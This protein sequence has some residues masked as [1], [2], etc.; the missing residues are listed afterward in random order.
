[1]DVGRT[2][3]PLS[4]SPGRSENTFERPTWPWQTR[5]ANSRRSS[6][7]SASSLQTPWEPQGTLSSPARPVSSSSSQSWTSSSGAMRQ[8]T[9]STVGYSASVEDSI[10]QWSF[11]G[12]EWT[13]RDVHKLRDFVEGIAEAEEGS[14]LEAE[15]FEI[16]KQAPLLG[17]EKFKLEIARADIGETS[18]VKPA[19][20]MLYITS[21][22][23]FTQNLNYE[24][25]AS[26]M[27][28]IKSQEDR[29][30]ARAE[31]VWEH[32]DAGW[33]F[34]HNSE[35]FDCSLPPISALLENPRIRE[36]DAFTICVQIHCPLG[37]FFPQ[38]PTAYYVPRDLLE[39]LEAS[40]DNPNTGDVRFICLERMTHDAE[41]PGTPLS[42]SAT[43]TRRPSSSASSLSPFSLQ[44]TARKR[45]IYAHSDILTRRS[46]YFATMLSSSFA[47]SKVT[48]GDRK[49]FTIVVEEAD[50]ETI[51]WLLKYCY[52]NWLQFKEND[53]PRL[54]V[55]G[56]GAGWSARW[57]SARGGEWDW[58]TFTKI[59]GDE[60]T[61]TDARSA[62]KRA[63]PNSL[64][65]FSTEL[66]A[67]PAQDVLQYNEH[68]SSIGNVVQLNS[69]AQPTYSHDG[70]AFFGWYFTLK[71]DPH[72]HPTPAP[73]PASALA[74][75][76][77]AH[78]YAMPAL[79]SLALDHMMS[80][81]TPSSAFGLLLATSVWDELHSLVMDYV[82]EK[83]ED[84]S[85]SPEF[86]ICCREVSGGEWGP[87]GGKTLMGLF[88]RLRWTMFSFR[89]S[90][91]VRRSL[92]K[93]G[94]AT[95]ATT[96]RIP[97]IDFSKF[98][99]G[100]PQDKQAT[101]NE[102]VSA[103]KESG[104]IY[105]SNH[106][107]PATVVENVFAK[108]SEFF[109]LPTQVKDQLAWADP[110]S[111]RGYV[112]TGR[113]R[114]T[115]ATDAHEIAALRESAPD[116]KETMEIGRDWDS[117]WPNQWPAETAAP[118]FKSTMLDF[119]NRCHVLHTRVMRA[120]ALG[121][122]LDEGFFEDK[123]HEQS[124]NLRL[125]SYPPIKRSLLDGQGQA[126]AGAHSDYGTLTLLFQ[127]D[128]GGLEAKNPHTGMFVPATPIPGT[129]V[130]NVGDL[131]SRWSNDLLRS[132]LHRVVAPPA[133]P[134]NAQEAITRER[135]SIAFFCNP[136]FTQEIA[137]LPNCGTP[138][139][140]AVSTEAY[141]VGRLASTYM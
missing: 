22:L 64:S 137:C 88:R 140:P 121:L 30:G 60:G 1:M 79:A 99:S 11:M 40:L 10:R 91:L 45:V 48:H 84:V 47:E 27:V 104:F 31:W 46:E 32:W 20:L 123:I 17:D 66:A 50:F 117:V 36:M 126:R 7:L 72:P 108:S 97:L 68:F 92:N 55:E 106:G 9:G 130:V 73:P 33:I 4:S 114:V 81:I 110:R 16:L 2:A 103:F 141:I 94:L 76:Q 133:T 65:L 63:F 18:A 96:F 49:L 105:L 42:E 100:S 107:I 62:T 125:L 54:A 113:E 85:T 134:I 132:T 131:L 135:K 71:A 87:E 41:L 102:I 75:Y 129:I 56:I 12:F 82:T 21:L 112:A 6:S 109:K 77:I 37:P 86:E 19:A 57:L 127:D 44:T 39:G 74:M 93:R 38:Q 51:Y 83:W 80:T 43:T 67:C 58:K 138:K 15:S 78:R 3:S 35:V 95:E 26:I 116:C 98:Q 119:F 13:V 5:I 29:V 124:H 25:S 52:A 118:L 115:Q 122:E 59:S 89:A 101:A 128:V 28:A 120:I 69:S 90:I 24:M 14:E 139:Y 53:D 23:D 8:S 111:N 34:R 61:V 136:N 70:N